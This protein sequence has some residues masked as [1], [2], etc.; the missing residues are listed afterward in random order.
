MTNEQAK[1]LAEE[2]LQTVSVGSPTDVADTTVLFQDEDGTYSVVDNGEE[3]SGL[4]AEQA[5]EV[6]IGNLT[7]NSHE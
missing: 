4:T 6:I 2:A 5:V 7:A 3:V 1:Q